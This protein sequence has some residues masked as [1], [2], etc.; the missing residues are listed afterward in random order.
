M[1]CTLKREHIR[2]FM[3]K[4]CGFQSLGKKIRGF[5]KNRVWNQIRGLEERARIR[6]Q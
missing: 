3:K 6:E 2:G 1:K 4:I 5:M